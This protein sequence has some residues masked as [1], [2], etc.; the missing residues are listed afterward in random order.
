MCRPELDGE[1]DEL[2]VLVDEVAQLLRICHFHR[3]VLEVECD[4][5]APLQWLA[6]TVIRNLPIYALHR[7]QTGAQKQGDL[8]SV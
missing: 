7:Q 3:I 1:L 5:R 2:A 8:L 4:T 6:I